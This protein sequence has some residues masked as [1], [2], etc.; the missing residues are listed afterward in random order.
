MRPPK[1]NAAWAA[2]ATGAAMLMGQAVAQD[3]SLIHIFVSSARWVAEHILAHGHAKVTRRDIG[4]AS[5]GLRGESDKIVHAMEV[6]TDAGWC[7]PNAYSAF[8]EWEDVYKRQGLGGAAP[9][10]SEL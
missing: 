8:P 3:L 2:G 1:S 10:G 5:V 4:R 9:A 6:L 7:R